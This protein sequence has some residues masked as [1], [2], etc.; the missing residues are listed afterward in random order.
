MMGFEDLWIDALGE[1]LKLINLVMV[2]IL[3]SRILEGAN[4][5]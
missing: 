3:S 1:R 2:S 5:D 4:D